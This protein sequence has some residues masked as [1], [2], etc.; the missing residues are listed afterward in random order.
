LLTPSARSASVSD[1][2][3]SYL[4]SARNHGLT[5]LDAITRALTGNPWLPSALSHDPFTVN[6]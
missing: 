4:T 1:L 2:I 3:N 6:P 5:I